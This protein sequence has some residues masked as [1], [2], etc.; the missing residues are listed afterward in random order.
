MTNLKQISYLLI[1]YH[2]TK[3]LVNPRTEILQD[4]VH[5]MEVILHI[6]KFNTKF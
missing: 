4:T 1:Q 5:A 6:R 2:D 3:P